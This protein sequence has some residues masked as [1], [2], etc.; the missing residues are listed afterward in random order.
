MPISVPIEAINIEV[1]RPD[2]IISRVKRN[3][4]NEPSTYIF[5]GDQI[6]DI[7]QDGDSRYLMVWEFYYNPV[8]NVLIDS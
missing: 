4:T 5:S 6:M 8:I 2:N 1:V 3:F 7:V